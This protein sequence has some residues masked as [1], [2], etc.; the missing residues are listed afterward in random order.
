MNIRPCIVGLGYVGLP[1]FLRLSKNYSTI[2][3][4]INKSRIKE[5][6]SKIDLNSE[7]KKKELILNNNSNFTYNE[8]DIQSC[9][10][11]II[12]VPTPI[13]KNKKPDLRPLILA[14]KIISKFIKK[15]DIVFYE[16]TVYPGVTEE[17]C[18]KIIEK[19]SKLKSQ[20]DF[21]VGYSP[22]RINPGDSV[23]KVE[24]INKIVAFKEVPYEIKNKIIN[25]YKKISKKIIL[26]NSIKE[27]E[28]SKVIENV[29]RDINIAFVN[30]IFMICQK[31]D[32]NFSN[33]I[34]LASTKWNFLKFSPGLVGGHCLPVDP[35]YLYALAKKNNINAKFMLAGRN[36]NNEMEN[37]VYKSIIQKINSFSCKKILIAGATYKANVADVRNSLALNIYK[38]LKKNKNF[39]TYC[40]DPVI[41]NK[42]TKKYKILDRLNLNIN[43]DLIVPLVPHTKLLKDLSLYKNS[44]T[45]FFDIFDFY[46]K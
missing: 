6:K 24:K 29:Q 46:K 34:K 17:V 35:Y 15:N 36:V 22:E 32:L 1:I 37:F 28:T 16:S 27:S 43:F 18:T 42:Y 26:S 25:V 2:G 3:F 21:F 9:N 13:Y 40:F 39:N 14:T 41:N 44:N 30:E 12:T 45:I 19:I 20:Q 38:R 4:D 33:I 8:K 5:L 10:F 11:F 31:L 23:H 7:Y